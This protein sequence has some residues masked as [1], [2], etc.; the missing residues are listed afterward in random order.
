LIFGLAPLRSAVKVPMGLALKTSS[1]TSI[2]DHRR[3][4]SGQAVIVLQMSLC[5]VLLIAA[6]L[7]L[8]TLRN[9]EHI[10]LGM[11]TDSLLVFGLNPQ[12]HAPTDAQ[13]KPFFQ[14][15]VERM[16]RIPGVQSATAMVH[17]IGAG[18][19][20]NTSVYI[21]GQKPKTADGSF[22]GVRWNA[23]GP[24]FLRTLGVPLL[25]GRDFNDSDTATSPLAIIVNQTFVKRYLNGSPA[26]GHQVALHRPNNMQ[27]TIVGVCGDSK[28]SSI[29][30][31]PRP[32]AYLPY[33]QWT[34]ID[35][36]QIELRTAGDPE[37]YWPQV[38]RAVAEFAPDLPLLTPT[39][40]RQQLED[41]L[42]QE[43]LFAR[44]S[45]FF[46]ALAVLLVAT[47]LY[48]T[49]AYKVAR[50]TPEIGIRMALG[51]QRLDVLWMVLRESLVLCALA[52]AIGLPAG[53]AL[54]RLMRSML[55]G[56]EPGDPIALAAS[57]AGIAAV[58]LAASFLP[59]RK[60][61][62][63]DPMVALRCE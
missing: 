26:V 2:Q 22:A 58:A 5:L 25:A 31:D 49:L 33:T 62:A 44:L 12:Q 57:L 21:D 48:A 7:L 13:S 24:D 27:F 42:S 36:M 39:T 16:R 10:N 19:S 43:R 29:R 32:M 18:W 30:E 9:L 34:G 38:R 54:A 20:S 61:S 50:R 1:A 45:A 46:G 17:R 28:Y 40:Q 56:L 60:A 3:H 59:A 47:G 37:T 41:T 8:R 53:F 63:V 35:T 6:G 52:I 11:N 55:Y 14:T 51:A 15:M 4:R 23:V